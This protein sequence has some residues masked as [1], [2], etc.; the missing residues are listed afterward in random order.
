MKTRTILRARASDRGHSHPR[1]AMALD[2]AATVAAPCDL[3][4][5]PP[6]VNQAAARGRTVLGELVPG[7]H[8]PPGPS[9]PAAAGVGVGGEW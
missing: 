3:G 4:S 1:D 2:G 7:Q 5:C 9:S 8:Q 6:T